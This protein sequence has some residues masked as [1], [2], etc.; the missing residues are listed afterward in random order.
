MPKVKLRETD[1]YYATEF[2]TIHNRHG[3][4]MKDSLSLRGYYRVRIVVDGKQTWRDVHRLV[5]EAFNGKP[6][7]GM[8]IDH[9]DNNH[10]NNWLDN[11]QLLTQQENVRKG[12]KAG[13]YETNREAARK[14]AV[15]AYK[16]RMV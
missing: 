11:L 5:W 8:V 15:I 14:N 6:P 12:W 7:R 9:I 10:W 16:S 2:G 3:K 13:R 4:L 1:N